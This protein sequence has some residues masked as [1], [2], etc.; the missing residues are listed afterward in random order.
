MVQPN[1]IIAVFA[2]W[3][4]LVY[5]SIRI[6]IVMVIVLEQLLRITVANVRVAVPT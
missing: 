2:P 4:P 3:E 5:P 6:L 1:M